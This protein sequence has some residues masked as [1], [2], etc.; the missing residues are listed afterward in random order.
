MPSVG[1]AKPPSTMMMSSP[2]SK[3][4]VFFPISC[5][6]PRGITLKHGSF[7]LMALDEAGDEVFEFIELE[8]WGK[9]EKDELWFVKKAKVIS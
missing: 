6:P 3:T 7:D 9:Y 4:Q 5:K 8:S 2:Y 1:K